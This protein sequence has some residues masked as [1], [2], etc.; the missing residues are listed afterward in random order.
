[1]PYG[2]SRPYVTRYLV[3]IV[4]CDGKKAVL[5]RPEKFFAIFYFLLDHFQK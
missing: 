2:Q 1:M 5:A 3:D 4:A